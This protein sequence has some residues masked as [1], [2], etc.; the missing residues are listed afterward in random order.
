MEDLEFSF[1]NRLE[2][3]GCRIIRHPTIRERELAADIIG[4]NR[5][6]FSKLGADWGQSRVRQRRSFWL[7]VKGIRRSGDLKKR[8]AWES[9]TQVVNLAGDSAKLKAKVFVLN[10]A[11][12]RIIG[13]VVDYQ[14]ATRG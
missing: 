3:E 13:L 6:E 11:N 1:T 10:V 9:T 4:V 14:Y 5:N 7:K 8:R 2:Y 12:G